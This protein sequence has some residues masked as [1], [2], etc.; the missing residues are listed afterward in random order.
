MRNAGQCIFLF[1]IISRTFLMSIKVCRH[2]HLR[3]S[4]KHECLVVS[5]FVRTPKRTSHNQ[6]R[7][8][9]LVQQVLYRPASPDQQWR[10]MVHAA[11]WARGMVHVPTVIGLED[12]GDICRKASRTLWGHCRVKMGGA[13]DIPCAAC[14]IP[15]WRIWI[16]FDTLL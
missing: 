14:T 3:A 5:T 16:P 12:F 11:R 13:C 4:K 8:S 9:S 1:S 2:R 10:G 6:R 7:S 15:Q